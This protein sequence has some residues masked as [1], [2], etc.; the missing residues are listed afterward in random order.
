MD[1]TPAT[2]QTTG[3]EIQGLE[4]R[5]GKRLLL[6]QLHLSVKPGEC[7]ALLGPS[8]CGKTTTLRLLAGLDPVSGGRILLDGVDITSQPAGQR[9]VA[10]VF[11]SYA[12]YPH[13]SVYENLAL[14]LRIRGVAASER[15]SRIVTIL[16]LLQLVDLQQRRPAQL[17]GGQRQRVAL[18]RALL[19]QPD[20]VLLDEPMS[21]LDAQL[22]EELRPEL[23]RLLCGGRP[24]VL[25][26]THDQHEA[27][28]MADRIAILRGGRL[29]QVGTA[30]ELYEQP[31]NLFVAG[32]LGRPAINL[33][34]PQGLRQLALRPEHLRPVAADGLPA[35]VQR[36]EWLGSQQ[37][38][39][40]ETARGDLRMLISAQTQLSD[41]LQVGWD[42]ADERWFSVA[43]GVRLPAPDED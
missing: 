7:L 42:A 37:L 38:V 26:V 2:A 21:N 22:R 4:R 39:W 5:L 30:R 27:M 19:R 12:L 29:Q 1:R 18:A 23:R 34:S 25:Y 16:E 35:R 31:C 24:P 40:L 3:L 8:G 28:G 9:R 11:Q 15:E 17:S 20:L 6:E 14:G 32:F 13:L 10:M 36:R 41:S 33:L 43:D